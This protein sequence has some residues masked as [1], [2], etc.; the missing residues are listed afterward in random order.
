MH[1]EELQSFVR[2][3][4]ADLASVRSSLLI[5]AQT[6]DASDLGVLHAG[7]SHVKTEAQRISQPGIAGLASDC[8]A[9]LS[10][11]GQDESARSQATYRALDL[12]A[13]IEA[14]LLNIPIRSGDFLE[15][16]SGFVDSSFAELVPRKNE[17]V[18][19]EP[20]DDEQFEID[21]ETLEIFRSEAD[22]LL[23]NIGN[24]IGQL[25]SSPGD[26][27]A[28]WEMRRNAH[29]FKGAAGIVG[30][31]AASVVAHRMEDL[32]DKMVELRR[33]A[34]P[35]VVDFLNASYCNL[36]DIVAAK[37]AGGSA[38]LDEQYEK[39]M[40]WLSS[41]EIAKDETPSEQPTAPAAAPEA[42]ERVEVVKPVS[43]PIVRVSLERLDELLRISHNLAINRAAVAE[44]FADF[45]SGDRSSIDPKSRLNA[46]FEIG[47]RLTGEMQEKLLRI[48]M[49]KFGTLETRLSRAVHITSL[50][51]NKKATL[52]IEDPDVEIDTLVID[53][54]EP[55]LHLLK[56]LFAFQSPRPRRPS[57]NLKPER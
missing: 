34:A 30:L 35:H 38:E 18:V 42:V 22:E 29:T 28:L 8:E 40:E 14:E 23:A 49:V 7:L 2:T 48:R 53:A 5:I 50:D 45:T 39:V 12:V 57:A 41:G 47:K 6:G 46:L 9:V 33:E 27:K 13:A 55:L 31:T 37:T 24:A 32:L 56:A 20:D 4:E 26:Q 51:E 15:D 54:S 16:V 21:D 1:R 43:T 11:L 25:R 36:N 19:P 3:A 44:G 17:P 52:V 10:V